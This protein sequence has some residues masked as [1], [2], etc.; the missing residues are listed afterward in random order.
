LGCHAIF[1]NE[2]FH[3]LSSVKRLTSAEVGVWLIDSLNRQRPKVY[4]FI[5]E[6]RRQIFDLAGAPERFNNRVVKPSNLR[7]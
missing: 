2:L 3:I 7:E 5:P 6:N 4:G 1:G